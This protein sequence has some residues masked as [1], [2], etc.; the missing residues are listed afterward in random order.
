MSFTA[1]LADLVRA[2]SNGLLAKHVSWTRV[3]LGDV[4]EILNGFA[5]PSSRFNK[6]H[7]FPLLRIRDIVGSST[8][9]HYSGDFDP[10]YLVNPGDLVVGMDGDFNSALWKGKP[11]LLNQR[12]CKLAVDGHFYDL[13]FLSYLL[14]GYLS[15]INHATSSITVKH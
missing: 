15:E 1:S 6:V 9:T 2:N 12:V 10:L 7:G 8:E 5:F 4:S 11:A 13:K 3:R 14:P